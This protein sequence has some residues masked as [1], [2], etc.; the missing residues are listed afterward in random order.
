VV[1][2]IIS[3]ETVG[4]YS[5]IHLKVTVRVVSSDNPEKKAHIG[6]KEE[7]PKPW[8]YGIPVVP[9]VAS[10]NCGILTAAADPPTVL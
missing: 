6:L 10:T 7:Q 3:D 8:K 9:I 4:K 2:E 5:T 1:R